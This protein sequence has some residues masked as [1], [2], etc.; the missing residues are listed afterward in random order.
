MFHGFWHWRE[1]KRRLHWHP[2]TFV[3][4]R[5]GH[6]LAAA[7]VAHLRP[8]DLGLGIDLPDGRRLARCL[9]CDSWREIPIPSDPITDFL[10]P[11]AEIRLPRRGE[12]L[13]QAI[14]LRVI[15]IDRAIHVVIFGLLFSA[16]LAFRLNIG[17]LHA[18]AQAIID[19][20]KATAANSSQGGSQGFIVRELERL[21]NVHQGTLTVLAATALAYFVLE[22][23]EAIGLWKEKRWAEYL[24]AVATGGLLP[25]EIL[26][27][28]RRVT[29]IRV[30]ALVI[31]VAIVV[32]LVYRKRLFGI[33]GGAKALEAEPIDPELL[34]APPLSK[35]A[36][37]A[38]SMAPA[39]EVA[40]T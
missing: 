9:R 10:P 28:S 38:A 4:S 17:P 16:A 37:A 23:V 1:W 19:A 2:E 11:L 29:V 35:S 18:Q 8:Q 34:L 20:L 3:C 6:V 24:T 13:R 33:A 22:L 31:N 21:M 39:K 30:G 36:P 27:L 14:I 5:R 12:A 26:E 15:A 32:W 40:G 7:G 25:F